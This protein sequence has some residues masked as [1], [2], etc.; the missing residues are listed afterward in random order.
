MIYRKTFTEKEKD[1]QLNENIIIVSELDNWR[2]ATPLQ[3]RPSKNIIRP[4]QVSIQHPQ[5]RE[6]P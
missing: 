1:R 6:S 5:H 4:D 2:P 3:W